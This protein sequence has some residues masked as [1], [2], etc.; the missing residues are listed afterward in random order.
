MD[1]QAFNH[2]NRV[3]VNALKTGHVGLNVTD[4]TRSI[5][6]YQKVL[7]LTVLAERDADGRRFA[8]LGHE[9]ELMLTLWQQSTG[10][11]ATDR[12][13]LHHLAF[14]VPDRAAVERAEATLRDLGANLVHDGIVRHGEQAS[15]GGVFFTDPDGVRLEIYAPEV[16]AEAPAPTPG[17][18]TCGFF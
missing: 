10:D 16:G 1:R 5:T 11:F 2:E 4:L 12:P 7:D 3:I 6:F 9:G 8:M 17:A 18:P 13:G 15:S 14:E